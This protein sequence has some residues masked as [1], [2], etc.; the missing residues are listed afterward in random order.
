MHN[1]RS[2]GELILGSQSP[3]RQEILSFF[4]LKIRQISS[5]FDEDYS[6]L[7]TG[8]CGLC[9]RNRKREGCRSHA[10]ISEQSDSGR[11]KPITN[12]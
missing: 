7:S 5:D 8:S 11:S 9:P 3:R 12:I 1:A 2:D 4:S 6:G 10:A